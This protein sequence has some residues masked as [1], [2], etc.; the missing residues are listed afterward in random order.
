MKKKLFI[1]GV[2]AIFLLFATVIAENA[3][4]EKDTKDFVKEI[5]RG[6][7]ID[8]SKIKNVEKVNLKE[9]PNEVKFENIDETTIEMYKVNVDSEKPVYVITASETKIQAAIKK[10]SRKMLINFGESEVTSNSQ[11]LKSS[12]GVVGDLDKGYVMIRDGSVTGL[13][14]SLEAI[15]GEGNAEI[16]I[17]INGKEIGFR[18]TIF[19]DSSE[20]YTDYDT[21]SEGTIYFNKGDIISLYIKLDEGLNIKDINTLLEISTE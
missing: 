20:S 12:V 13:S 18:N 7:G 16:I 11:F 9:L 2:L 4:I 6:K 5:A 3:S 17:Y 15:S 10:F 21:I 8:S 19:I 14:T 1:F